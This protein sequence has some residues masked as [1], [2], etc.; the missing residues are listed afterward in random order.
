MGKLR[1]ISLCAIAALLGVT[2]LASQS[3]VGREESRDLEHKEII[4]LSEAFGH[5]IGKNLETPGFRFDL[6]A[7][8][9]GMHQAAEGKSSPMS[10]EEYGLAITK[11]QQRAIAALALNNL[12][13]ANSFLATNS[14]T[15]GINVLANGKL[16]YRIEQAGTGAEVVPGSA[17]LLHY[18]GRFLNGTSFGTSKGGEPIV[19]PLDQTIAGFAA[20]LVGMKEGEH[21]ILFVHPDLGYGKEGPLPPNSLLIFEVELVAVEKPV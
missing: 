1:V 20:G 2:L 10:E 21:R 17:P 8:V 14:Q 3:M 5:L 16:Q 19:L 15:P 12:E 4:S 11:M 6:E 9:R 18:T 7:V 13:E